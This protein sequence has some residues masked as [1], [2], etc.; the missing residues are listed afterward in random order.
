[1]AVAPC[2]ARTACP[3]VTSARDAATRTTL[4]MSRASVRVR[5]SGCVPRRSV[6]TCTHAHFCAVKTAA[7]V[8]PGSPPQACR[9]G[10]SLATSH[11]TWR[12]NRRR[13]NAAC[14]SRSRWHAARTSPLSFASSSSMRRTTLKHAK[15][16]VQPSFRAGTAAR[17]CVATVLPS[18]PSKHPPPTRPHPS[19]PSTETP[20]QKGWW[21]PRQKDHQN[22]CRTHASTPRARKSAGGRCRVGTGALTHAMGARPAHRAI[23]HALCS[24][25]IRRARSD[26]MLCAPP[27]SSRVHGR[28]LM[29]APAKSLVGPCSRRVCSEVCGR[30]LNCGH[31]CPCVCGEVC[32]GGKDVC[33][34]C[35]KDDVLN[36]VVDL[37]RLTTL[38]EYHVSEGGPLVRLQCGHIFCVDSLDAHLELGS[39]YAR[40]DQGWGDALPISSGKLVPLKGCPSC[41]VPITGVR[42]YGRVINKALLDQMTVKYVS[43]SMR[44]LVQ[45]QDRVAVAAESKS[46]KHLRAAASKVMALKQPQPLQKIFNATRA[47]RARLDTPDGLVK[48][49]G[50]PDVTVECEV[51]LLLAWSRTKIGALVSE[52]D[53]G[54]FLDPET[55]FNEA[56]RALEECQAVTKDK[57]M[58]ETNMRARLA[59]AALLTTRLSAFSQRLKSMNTPGSLKVQLKSRV[60]PLAA[61][62]DIL[63]P[64][65][66]GACAKDTTKHQT[67]HEL[68]AAAGACQEAMM[69]ANSRVELLAGAA[70]NGAQEDERAALCFTFA[71]DFLSAA[72]QV[73]ASVGAMP[74]Q[75]PANA[76]ETDSSIVRRQAM[77]LVSRA[78]KMGELVGRKGARGVEGLSEARLRLLQ[79]AMDLADK[80]PSTGA[81]RAEVAAAVDAAK[82]KVE[83]GRR[84]IDEETV[85]TY[86]MVYAAMG[87]MENSG[88]DGMGNHWYQ[89]PAGHLYVIADCG[90][91][92]E[93]SVCPECGAVIGGVQHSVDATNSAASEFLELSSAGG[94]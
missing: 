90:G 83:T 64:V 66:Q 56:L 76:S 47:R 14:W 19:P 32:P 17:S 30:V 35:A 61:L 91:A 13:C 43:V 75:G 58:T 5:A 88:R 40:S 82:H 2:H 18:R 6:R 31:A 21:S 92:M 7:R 20:R 80:L 81:L 62:L 27:A 71:T 67:V 4:N 59:H 25:R 50:E 22:F 93:R 60:A 10:T 12:V 11:A 73:Q 33:R 1:M 68:V 74:H 37:H 94:E 42:R 26:V 77:L 38:R 28:A 34:W 84:Y 24:V 65:L 57:G 8:Q 44:Q 29:R 48:N 87:Y 69:V 63:S 54:Q 52:K 51:Q 85:Q 79:S 86:R 39:C 70:F 36:Q 41:R 9:V 45:L 46:L 15:P 3:V 72:A 49:I 55:S 53:E 16:S 23:A 89:C 78:D